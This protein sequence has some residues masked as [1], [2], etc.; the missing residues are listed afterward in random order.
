[1]NDLI[2]FDNSMFLPVQLTLYANTQ[3]SLPWFFGAVI[4]STLLPLSLL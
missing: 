3:V 1:M 4:I 2:H